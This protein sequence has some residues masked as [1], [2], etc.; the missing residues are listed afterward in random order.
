MNIV[1]LGAGAVGGYFG[2]RLAL[3]GSTVTSLVR[4]RRFQQLK[5]IGLH[6]ESIHGDFTVA[7]ELALSTD[8]IEN[9]DIVILAIKNYHLQSALPE[10]RDPVQRGA[11]VLP[12]MNGVQHMEMLVSEF[13]EESVLGG[14]CYRRHLIQTEK[15]SIQVQCT[16]S[17]SAL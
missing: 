12:L 2:G 5:N 10:I 13:G 16:I 6:I 14:L 9:P 7:P 17:S 15:L 11:K 3:A 8:E 1:V 4:E